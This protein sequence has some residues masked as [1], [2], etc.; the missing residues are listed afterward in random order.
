MATGTIAERLARLAQSIGHLIV[1]EG[2]TNWH[3]DAVRI[4]LPAFIYD[5]VELELLRDGRITAGAATPGGGETLPP[6]SMR[7]NGVLFVRGA[8]NATI[9][10]RAIVNG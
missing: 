5:Q 9:R 7:V 3:V 4:E 2:G 10:A 8:D 6:G 1:G